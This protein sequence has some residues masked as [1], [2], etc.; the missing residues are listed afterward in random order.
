MRYDYE[1]REIHCENNGQD[2]YGLAYI[3]EGRAHFPLVIFAH[4]LGATHAAGEGYAAALAALGTAVYTFDFCGGGVDGRSDGK[5]TEMSI[6]TEAGDLAAVLEAARGWEFVDERRIVLLGASQGGAVSAIAAARHGEDVAGLILLYPAF[7]I[8]DRVHAQFGALENVPEQFCFLDW[9]DVGRRYAA[10]IWAVDIYDTIQRYDGPVLLIHGGKD[11][12]TD[13]SY[14]ERAAQVYADARLHVIGRAGHGF[15]G[16]SY[17]E[18][19]GF[20]VDYLRDLGFLQKEADDPDQADDG[21]RRGKSQPHA[22]H[23]PAKGQ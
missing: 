3:P 10:D 2:I 5:T 19:V 11:T 12:I 4:Q 14:S 6:L 18:S 23:A 1:I 20:I 17:R 7:M 8:F 15:Y 9:V 16:R 21:L 22:G 13:L